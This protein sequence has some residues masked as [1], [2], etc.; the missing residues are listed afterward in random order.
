MPTGHFLCHGVSWTR[1][2]PSLALASPQGE[3]TSLDLPASNQASSE[4]V[5]G[6]GFNLGFRLD[7]G[8]GSR[9]CLGYSKALN[10][11]ERRSF[12]CPTRTTAER[13]YQCGPCF[14]R[15][16]FRYM[17]DVHRSG[18]APG[19][20]AQYLAQ[21]HWLYIATFADG[22]TKVGTA[23]QRSKWT[24][25]AE[26]GAV[27]ARYVAQADNGR[28]V[29]VLEDTVTRSAG[30]P[31][32]IRSAA[33]TAALARP[34]P[35]QRLKEANDDAAAAASRLLKREI[36]I[37]G[38]RTSYQVWDPPPGWQQVLAAHAPV[39]PLS[40][41]AGEHGGAVR[42]VLGQVAL[43]VLPEG[44]FLLDLAQLRGR[45]LELGEW[46]SPAIAVQQELF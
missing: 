20:L 38:Y 39:Y 46:R 34:L 44:E 42:A 28:V 21:E 23:S 40:L 18:V 10:G 5:C 36:D 11:G 32:A 27:V 13:G 7:D 22:S 16:D 19:G 1:E 3:R 2:G 31:Q 29:R 8:P 41:G 17:H 26:Q 15:D 37:D 24:R 35:Q 4:Q 30:L 14:A 45:R 43:L 25:L 6:G 33:K 9:Y 12:P